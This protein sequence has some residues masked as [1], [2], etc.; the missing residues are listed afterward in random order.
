MDVDVPHFALREPQLAA[1]EIG[2]CHEVL[3]YTVSH[4]EEE[5]V[6]VQPYGAPVIVEL[7][8]TLGAKDN[9]PVVFQNGLT[10]RQYAEVF[11]DHQLV[12]V[13]DVR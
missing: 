13:A 8:H 3:G 5:V 1:V 4:I 2:R 12:A 11:H 7:C 10:F 6:L 9:K